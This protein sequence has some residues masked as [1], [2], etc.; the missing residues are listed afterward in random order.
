MRRLYGRLMCAITAHKVPT[1]QAEN[2]DRDAY[3]HCSLQHPA[4]R[5]RG[6][7]QQ[8]RQQR[9]VTSIHVRLLD[10]ASTDRNARY[11]VIVHILGIGVLRSA[12]T[13]RR[14]AW[15]AG[16]NFTVALTPILDEPEA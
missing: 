1:D 4:H 9:K 15:P 2:E 3:G 7:N 14:L 16:C 5:G 11:N 8:Q 12:T 6:S 13:H 10:S